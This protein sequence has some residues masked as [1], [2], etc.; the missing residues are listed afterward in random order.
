MHS[1]KKWPYF[2]LLLAAIFWGFAFAA[3]DSAAVVPPFTLGACRC[4]IAGIFLIFVILILDPI[5]KSGR[6]LFSGKGIGI[7]KD[8]WIG[9]ALCGV[10]MAVATALQQFGIAGGTDGGKAAFITALYVVLVPVYSLFLGKKA[11]PHVWI[12]IGIAM[13]GFYLLC[14]KKDFTADLSDLF[15]AAGTLVF[16]FHI[17]TIGHYSSR[18]DCIRLSAVQF[19]SAGFVNLILALITERPVSFPLIWANI[20]PLLY[21]GIVS[22]GVAYTFQIIAQKYVNPTAASIILSL[23]SVFGVI[24]T[25]LFLHQTLSGREYAGCV[26]VFLAV[27]LSQLDFRRRKKPEAESKTE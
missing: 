20:L 5:R 21:L 17:L 16:P 4:F 24:G 22:S 7:Q 2:L 19:F 11:A 10:I 27:L 12:S 9:G 18:C 26:I 15:I 13:A 3:Q 1:A 14:I 6:R 25:A 23:E 8:E